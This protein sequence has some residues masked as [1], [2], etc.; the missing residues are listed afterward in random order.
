MEAVRVS[1]PIFS[2][3]AGKVVKKA[4]DKVI[5]D[6]AKVGVREVKSEL[7]RGHGVDSGA[8]K[9]TVRRRK[10]G[11]SARVYSSNTMI[12]L[13]LQGTQKRNRTTRF[14]GYQIFDK[15][16]QRTDATAG[17]QARRVAAELV[18]ELGG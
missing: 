2:T 7:H 6:V 14:K 4:I 8:F 3:E 12:A 9:R 5:I 16:A 1:G 10:K 13:W 18:R 17:E 11:L 15:A